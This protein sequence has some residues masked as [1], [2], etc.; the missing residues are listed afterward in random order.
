MIP[1]C[2]L[3]N[4]TYPDS[5]PAK[6]TRPPFPLVSFLLVDKTRAKVQCLQKLQGK[7]RMNL[8]KAVSSPQLFTQVLTLENAKYQLLKHQHPLPELT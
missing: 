3:I 1:H 8:G 4:S 5:Q 2:L 7:R 6:P